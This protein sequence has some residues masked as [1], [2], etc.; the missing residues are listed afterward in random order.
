MLALTASRVI[1]EVRP[2]NPAHMHAVR[3]LIDDLVHG[4]DRNINAVQVQDPIAIAGWRDCAGA[5]AAWKALTA[6]ALQGS[7]PANAHAPLLSHRVRP[8]SPHSLDGCLP[9]PR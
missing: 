1:Y 9:T 5:L 4:L 3:V 2:R 8:L 6:D 7:G